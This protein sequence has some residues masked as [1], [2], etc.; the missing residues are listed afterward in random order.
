MNANGEVLSVSDGWLSKLG[1]KREEVLGKHFSCFLDEKSLPQVQ[2][3]FPHL[4]DYGF[5]NNVPLIMKMKNGILS[6]AVLNGIS[7]YDEN[8]K[9]KNTICEIRTVH[10]ILNSEQEVKKILEQEKFLRSFLNI[11][12]NVLEAMHEEDNLD[13]FLNKLTVIL[14]EPLEI[15]N[16]YLDNSNDLTKEKAD[17]LDNIYLLCNKSGTY[18]IYIDDVEISKEENKSLNLFDAFGVFGS[19]V[20]SEDYHLNIVFILNKLSLKDD[21]NTALKDII[22]LIDYAVKSILNK[23]KIRMQEQ[24]IEKQSK[25]IHTQSKITSIGNML[26]NISH[27]WLQPLAAISM[28]MN[29][30]KVSMALGEKMGDEELSKTADNVMEKC[31]YLSQTLDDFK[32]FMRA[33]DDVIKIVNLENT[34]SKV[35]NLVTETFDK[36]HI[37]IIKNIESCKVSIPENTLIQSILNILNN[38]KDAMLYNNVDEMSRFVFIDVKSDNDEVKISINDS[39]GGID[40]D[41]IDN[42][43]EPYFTTKFESQGKGMGLYLTYQFITESLNSKIEVKNSTYEYAGKE[44]EGA[45]FIIYIPI[46]Q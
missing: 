39:A 13:I 11:K 42:I 5:V 34:I 36:D 21:W 20:I 38:S 19:V 1:Y 35:E 30:I 3:N 12:A 29:N 27:Q 14:E 37:K 23:N 25:I 16:V 22:S 17:A 10:D 41:I 45:E 43:F 4:K 15:K 40:E 28:S 32:E 24:E 33:K 6:E 8:G 9:F 18:N 44:L 31:Q 46:Q 26:E 2:K 7:E